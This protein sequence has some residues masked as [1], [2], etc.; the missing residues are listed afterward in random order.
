MTKVY[1]R[2][3]EGGEGKFPVNS[4]S[5][6]DT[7]HYCCAAWTNHF[8]NALQQAKIF[9]RHSSPPIAALPMVKR[10]LRRVQKLTS[11]RDSVADSIW[12][13]IPL[14]VHR[15]EA[16]PSARRTLPAYIASAVTVHASKATTRS[17]QLPLQATIASR[18]RINLASSGY[19]FD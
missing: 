8:L 18:L 17:I 13:A 9:K 12:T 19:Y 2:R 4:L 3:E 10:L 1:P 5:P 7:W 14:L 15:R 16:N 6:E 11:F